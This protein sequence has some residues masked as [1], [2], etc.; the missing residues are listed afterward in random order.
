MDKKYTSY[1]A[2][3]FTQDISF[4]NMV[5]K[6]TDHDK[7]ETLIQQHPELSKDI[8][9]A[10]KVVTALRFKNKD[11]K[12]EIIYE[13][14]EK[15]EP[16]YTLHHPPQNI[17]RYRK[18]LQYAALFLLVLSL[19]AA[20]PIFYFSRLNR[21]FTKIANSSS[22]FN[23]ARLILPGG[24]EILLTKNQ[25][26]LQF[27]AHGNKILVDQD[28]V[29]NINKNS[30][31][32]TMAQ[33]VIP[34]GKRSNLLLSDGTKVWLNAGS[35]LIFPEKFQGRNR[36]VFLVGE[37][38]FD[39]FKNKDVPFIVT[40]GN[41]AITVHGTQFN[42][43]NDASD[44]EL[45]VVLVEGAVSLKG[46]SML[47]FLG[48]E[49]RLIPNQ[50]AIYNK[51]DNKTSV[52]SNVDVSSYTS[53]KEGLLEFD[54]ESILTVFKKLSRF[55]N[56]SF[57]TESSIELNRKISGKLDLK[58]SLKDVMEVVSDAAP[59]SFR[60]DQNKVFVYSKI[61]YLPMR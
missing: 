2:E 27:I 53:W 42:V 12:E 10:R 47:N 59:I 58:A 57:V 31:P 1:S 50:R 9:T 11:I 4:I 60:I 25:S 56:V 20:L 14:Y 52:E 26:E 49:T 5:N 51:T 21:E 39:V 38:Y 13:L 8:N 33:I 15:I 44:N 35:K 23:D 6:G 37:A 17:F 48:K 54:R 29:V 3:D 55:Y 46:N 22:N 34:Y 30:D 41:L 43:R 32:N 24:K 40:T 61:N 19:G 7:W 28:T 16:F 36:K 45:E 18:I